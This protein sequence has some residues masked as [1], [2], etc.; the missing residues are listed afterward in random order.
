MLTVLLG[1]SFIMG[2][3]VSTPPP[4]NNDPAAVN[5][6]RQCESTTNTPTYAAC[7]GTL[8]GIYLAIDAVDARKGGR[9]ICF[10]APV[11]GDRL[12]GLFSKYVKSKPENLHLHVGH[13]A[14]QAFLEAFPCKK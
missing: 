2:Q 13:V 1:A 4:V 9:E 7:R 10:P 12:I 3:R 8:I 6:V 14:Y 5:L 11:Y